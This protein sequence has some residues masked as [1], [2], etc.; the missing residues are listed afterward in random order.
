LREACDN[1][2]D[3]DSNSFLRDVIE[4]DETCIGGKEANKPRHAGR[5]AV[6]KTGVPGIR[7]RA[8]TVTAA[9]TR[10]AKNIRNATQMS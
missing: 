3:D 8:G 5:G 7:E 9:A 4:A 1:Q 6:D 2:N 10:S